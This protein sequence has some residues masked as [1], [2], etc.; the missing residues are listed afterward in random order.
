MTTQPTN[1]PVPSESYRDLKFNA[2]KIDEFVT[3][4]VNTY[5][6]RFGNEHYT[7]EGLRWLAQQAIA[8]YGWIP[9]GTFQN[10][11]TLTLPNQ[12]IKDTTDGEYYRWDGVLPKVVPAGSTPETSGGLGS[13]SWLSIG[14]AVIRSILSSA[15]F[16]AF[17]SGNTKE[18]QF[19]NA[20]LFCNSNEIDIN[21]AGL[22]D[23][24][25]TGVD[26]ITI[27][28][29]SI[30]FAGLTVDVSEWSG[31]FIV[32]DVNGYNVFPST[33]TL[34]QSLVSQGVQS[35][36]KLNGWGD[37][38]DADDSYIRIMTNQPFFTY[39]G[40]VVN[41]E[42]YNKHSRFGLMGSVLKYD[43]DPT[44]ITEIRVLK[45]AKKWK[46]FGNVNFHLGSRDLAG[47]PEVVHVQYAS[48]TKLNDIR[49][50]LD[51]ITYQ[52]GNPVLIALW[53]SCHITLENIYCQ[54]PLY[55]TATTGYTYDISINLCY[56]VTLDKCDGFGDGW[57]ATGNNSTQIMKVRDSKLSRIDFHQPF[58]ELLEIS[59][60]S[61]GDAGIVITA[62]GDLILNNPTFIRADRTK[63]GYSGG[64]ITTRSDTGGFCDGNIIINGAS[65]NF[66]SETPH[67]LFVH[68]GDI[69]QA[70]P[71]GS[72][73][74]Y[75]F[76]D[77]ISI[78]NIRN[79][80]SGTLGLFPIVQ[81]GV[82]ITFPASITIRDCI[83]GNFKFSGNLSSLTPSLSPS[84]DS[85]VNM[86]SPSNLT[87]VIDNLKCLYT[88]R[89]SIVDTTANNFRIRLSAR[90]MYG[91]QGGKSISLQMNF[92]GT[93]DL[94]D[95]D[96]E[97][98]DF[99]TGGGVTKYLDLSLQSCELNYQSRFSSFVVNGFVL[100]KTN[101]KISSSRV[102]LPAS[103]S[104]HASALSQCRLQGNSYYNPTDG[105][106]EML[107]LPLPTSQ[108]IGVLAGINTSNN[109]VL[110][111][112]G[113][114]KWASFRMPQ[115]TNEISYIKQSETTWASVTRNSQTSI[116][117]S[118]SSVTPSA[119]YIS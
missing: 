22:G 6:D 66:D 4:L 28:N 21:C 49:F 38:T 51:N 31:K 88:E 47:Q 79:N 78:S 25:I 53:D 26:D 3:S 11:A 20:V 85:L 43:L 40:N 63:T 89:V 95:C 37:I 87:V 48:L 34:V 107:K 67:N 45:I 114:N 41:R 99:S 5:I 110:E 27:K 94:Y 19:R 68:Y 33:S 62:L 1:L 96:I 2:G 113:T 69:N 112:S 104:V 72:P 75:R 36:A 93:F 10:G 83:V 105:S 60:S 106:S 50:T 118:G 16:V 65:L 18:E 46:T 86:I 9:V 64:F 82:G 58:R 13:G 23:F 59:D 12:I 111:M 90:K 81:S 35:G 84:N 74:N 100:G 55:S 57:G 80:Y 56:D 42:E 119:V 76:W 32:Q 29:I 14:D 44:K 15:G 70:K 117:L 108:S 98:I 24:S 97:S 30:D 92:A 54:W 7:I 39:R 17:F 52:N 77:S 115:V 61:I 116:F 101:V 91:T 103:Y 109:Y 102:S 73:I 71:V 8:Q